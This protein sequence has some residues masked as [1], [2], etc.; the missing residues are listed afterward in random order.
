MKHKIADIYDDVD[1][2][3]VPVYGL[4]EAARYLNIPASTLRSWTVGQRQGRKRAFKPVIE[5][6]EPQTR[7]LSF[8]NACEAHVCDALRRTHQVPLQRIRGAID[9]LRR[10]YPRTPHPLLDHQFATSG[11]DVFVDEIGKLI[12]LSSGGQTAMRECLNLYLARVEYDQSGVASKLFPFTRS[13]HPSESPRVVVLDPRV[14]FGRPVIVNTRI[15]TSV[16]Y[17]RWA[18]GESV[19]ALAEDYN[20]PLPEIEEALRC[21]H[22]SAA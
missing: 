6:A 20:R 8:G 11:V 10:L 16:I 9:I 1:P 21:E 3:D 17:E 2:R 18:A 4:T 15:A 19:E 14:L 5:I 22:R 12:N 7:M 13:E